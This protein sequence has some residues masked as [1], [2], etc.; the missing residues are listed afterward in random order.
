MREDN[1]KKSILLA[2][3]LALLCLLDACVFRPEPA[4]DEEGNVVF[5]LG[6]SGAPASLNPYSVR[7]EEGEAVLSLLYDRLFEEDM[8][9]GE[10]VGSLCLDYQVTPSRIGGMLW[11]IE[12]RDDVYWH[13]GEKLTASD[14]EF[15]LQSAK[16]LSVLYGYP[17]CEM[18][19]TT[20]IAVEDDTH[21]AVV[22]WGE[23][24]YVKQCLA[25]IPILP[26]HIWN[27]PEYMRYNSSGVAADPLRA[28]EEA[29]RITPN[30]ANM[31]GSGLYKWNGWND[32]TCY[33]LLNRDYWNGTARAEAVELR[34]SL[35]DPAESLRAGEIDACWDASLQQYQ[36]LWNDK[37]HHAASGAAG[38]LYLVYFNHGK[39]ASPVRDV[40][41][42]SAVDC[43]VNRGQILLNAFGGGYARRTLLSPF[44][45]WDYSNELS[46]F[47]QND[48]S[49]AAALLE[50][51]GY[52]DIDGDG[53]RETQD[54]KRLT[55]T[56]GFGSDVSAWEAA[57]QILADQCR[58]AGI[59][60]K[61]AAVSPSMLSEAMASGNCD[62]VLTSVQTRPEPWFS[63][64]AFYWDQGNNDFSIP[65]GRGNSISPGWNECGYANATY[66]NAYR[67]LLAAS[68]AEAI[69]TAARQAGDILYDDCAAV[70]I[71][72]SVR[73]QA[74]SCVWYGV[75]TERSTGLAFTGTSLPRQLQGISAGG[76]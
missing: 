38:E 69:R 73:Y 4:K 58:R 25:G 67:R 35:A 46:S 43:C 76:K 40:R 39:A 52:R 7:D 48:I 42:R 70:P 57:A 26:R 31:V 5:R 17:C 37:E 68:E 74:W 45:P 9:T 24:A 23:E 6:F 20:G 29:G 61:L 53:I 32:G 19:D 18:L 47:R 1:K 60:I 27:Q 64:G 59:E 49:A 41:V 36:A 11:R 56:L 72:C 75:K 13:D 15:S 12:L 54:G 14:V 65:D 22:V 33:L 30:A 28:R 2:V 55:L 66:D 71:G 10:I 21:L 16:D 50:S 62:A 8:T 3:L 51:A 44:S 63:L 34:F